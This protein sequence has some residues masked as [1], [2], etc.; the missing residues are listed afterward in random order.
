LF[1]LAYQPGPL[2]DRAD[3]EAIPTGA[4][5][6]ATSHPSD[7]SGKRIDLVRGELL[8]PGPDILVDLLRPGGAGDDAADCRLGAT[9]ELAWCINLQTKAR[10]YLRH[11]DVI[12]QECSQVGPQELGTGKM[13]RVEAAHKGARSQCCSVIQQRPVQGD[14]V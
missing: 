5:A 2:V 9:R 14:Q 10:S 6:A 8:A 1:K 13:N 4:A 11:A 3:T 12:G 7:E